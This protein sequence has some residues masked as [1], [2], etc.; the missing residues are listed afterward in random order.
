[1]I[2]KFRTKT[3][4]IRFMIDELAKKNFGMVMMLNYKILK[5]DSH[6]FVTQMPVQEKVC[7]GLSFYMKCMNK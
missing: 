3:A 5:K 2:F 7:D 4:V 1:M 6:Y